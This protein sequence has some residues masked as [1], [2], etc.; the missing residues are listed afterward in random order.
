MKEKETE[1]GEGLYGGSPF[2]AGVARQECKNE[3]AK[4]KE[5]R[6]ERKK[7]ENACPN[8]LVQAGVNAGKRKRT[9]RWVSL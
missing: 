5:H 7:C 4:G 8:E 6:A 1:K 3:G 2:R 9:V